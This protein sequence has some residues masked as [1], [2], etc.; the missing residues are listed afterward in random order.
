EQRGLTGSQPVGGLRGRRSTDHGHRTLFD[1]RTDELRAVFARAANR[2]EQRS[3]NGQARIARHRGD[4]DF[5]IAVR[6]AHRHITQQFLQL[7]LAT[8]ARRRS[9][10][11]PGIWICDWTTPLPTTRLPN[12]AP[13]P[14]ATPP[15]P[16]I[17]PLPVSRPPPA[18]AVGAG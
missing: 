18:R 1:R 5:E 10:T 4:L 14:P 17:P 11:S 15:R 7:H 3:A 13:L 8:S 16:P 12:P 9:N 6:R 2:H